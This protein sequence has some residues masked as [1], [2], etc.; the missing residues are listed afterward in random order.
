[1][2]IE[3]FGEARIMEKIHKVPGLEGMTLEIA[4]TLLDK[5]PAMTTAISIDSMTRRSVKGVHGYMVSA[6]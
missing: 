5:A 4:R 6:T 2:H 3:R 1:M